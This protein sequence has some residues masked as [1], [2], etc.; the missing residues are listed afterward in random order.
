MSMELT[1]EQQ[2][3]AQR[4]DCLLYFHHFLLRLMMVCQKDFLH[5]VKEQQ[6]VHQKEKS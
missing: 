6:K 3:L 4:M 5:P 2:Y 1:K